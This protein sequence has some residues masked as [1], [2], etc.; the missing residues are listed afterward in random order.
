MDRRVL[1]GGGIVV[2]A[3]V[4]VGVRL[5]V[6]SGAKT[7][8]DEAL[9][10]LPP[11]FTATHGAVT[12]NALTGEAQVRDLAVAEDGVPLFAAG[13]V[14]VSGIGPAD[15]TGTPTRIESV[16][17]H[18]GV[19]GPYQ[20]IRRIDL[21]GVSLANLRQV[22]DP[23]AYPGGKPAWTDKRP[24]LDHGEIHG[25]DG[26]QTGLR[27]VHGV[28]V[29]THFD[30]GTV[31][32]DGLRL[33]QLPSPPDFSQPP[34]L[35]LAALEQGMAQ[36]AGSMKEMTFSM[37]GPAAVQGR[38]AFAKNGKFEDGRVTDMSFGD[39]KITTAKPAGTITVA[40]MSG[41]GLDM[42][43]M[44]HMLPAVIADPAKPHPEIL[45]GMHLD[46]A[47]VHG[48]IVD[49]PEGPLVT[50]D[51]ASGAAAPEG[52]PTSANF[53]I[54]AL[55]IKT[56]GRPLK[57]A[58]RASL[59]SFGMEDFTTD[60]NEDG[61]YDAAHGRFV[62]KRCD[63]TFRDLGALHLTVDIDGIPPG[64]VAT[65]PQV[66][67]VMASAQLVGA[68]VT[69]N[70]ASLTSRLMK[71]AAAKRGLTP[72]QIR[73]GLAMPLASLPM[74]MPE[75]PDAAEQINAFLDG[76]HT[77]AITLNPPQPVTMAQWRETPP[78]GKAALLGV[79]VSGN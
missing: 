8:L 31:T 53:K 26:E 72:A 6:N 68:S 22:M 7:G 49:Y 78:Q 77:L 75:Q 64:P 13:D 9:T 37:T 67:A 65:P 51:S 18:D 76:Q 2:A 36:D 69:W 29:K 57:S 54:H 11:G 19:A 50:L 71:M 41:E 15:A 62:L 33:S 43:K 45:N 40:G 46:S 12:Y 1:I 24:I 27:P 35:F 30:V 73:A 3:L 14:A 47:E 79:H 61:G 4:L 21:T 55:S 70:D 63:I 28:T 56:A 20:H 59:E 58:T 23:A 17:I 66:A 5:G 42:S 25:L 16:V 32:I 48:L 39:I 38:V 34:A 74:L 44:L 60:L 10:H 52:A